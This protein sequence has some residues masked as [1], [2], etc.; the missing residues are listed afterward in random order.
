M[1]HSQE[2][3]QLISDLKCLWKVQDNSLDSQAAELIAQTLG[4]QDLDLEA[5]EIQKK[6]LAKTREKTEAL[7][8][9]VEALERQS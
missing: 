4:K 9:K 8:K 1:T 6:V 7:L 2:H 5:F 3:A